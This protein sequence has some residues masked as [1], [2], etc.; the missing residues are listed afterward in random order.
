MNDRVNRLIG[1]AI[2]RQVREEIGTCKPA[3]V[4]RD[5]IEQCTG[6]GGIDVEDDRDYCI[7]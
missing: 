2:I 4:V 6:A 5:A 1:Y 7:G 3:K